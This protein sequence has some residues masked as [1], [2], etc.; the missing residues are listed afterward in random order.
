ME[1][2]AGKRRPTYDLTV[3]LLQASRLPT[4]GLIT[5][6]FPLAQWRTAAHTAARRRTG[7]IK[8]VLECTE[9]SP[10]PT[11]PSRPG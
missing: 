11:P 8:V 9:D 10:P 5:H 4:A 3:E 2:W 6:R 7:A 1:V